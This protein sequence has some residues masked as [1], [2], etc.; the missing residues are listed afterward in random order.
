MRYLL[1]S[2]MLWLLASCASSYSR[3]LPAQGDPACVLRFRPQIASALYNTQVNVVGNHLSGL[4]I[5]KKMPDSSTRLVFSNEAGFTYFDFGFSPAGDFRVYSIIPKM[6]RKAVIRTLRKDFAL[7]LMHPLPVGTATVH[8]ADTLQY[9]TFS[10]GRDHYYY[11]TDTA[12]FRLV[13]M[14]RGS[15]RKKVVEAFTGSY[16]NGVPGSVLIKHTGFEFSID[17]KRIE[18]YAD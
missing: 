14:E 9:H 13:R 10:S 16:H 15:K 17:L 7:V 11:I 18:K 2:S 1:S 4:L 8:R 6:N 12:C 5:I 3:L